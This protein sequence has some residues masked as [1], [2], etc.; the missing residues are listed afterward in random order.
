MSGLVLNGALAQNSPELLHNARD[1]ATSAGF[2]IGLA[3]GAV[4]WH[5]RATK[6]NGTDR[7]EDTWKQTNLPTLL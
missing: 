1:R 7:R 5:N 2:M 6:R 4:V 3:L